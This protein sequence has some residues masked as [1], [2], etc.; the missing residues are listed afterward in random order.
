[1]IYINDIYLL[2][3]KFISDY[4]LTK[5]PELMYKP[6]RP[7]TCLLI[8][9]H[10]DYLICIPFRSSITHKNSYLFKHSKRSKKTRSG[11]DY[12]KVVLIQN[13]EYIDSKRAIIDQDEYKE[14]IQNLNWIVKEIVDYIDTHTNH[15]SKIKR[16]HNKKFERMYKYSTL[17]YF[18]DI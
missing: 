14:T 15:V 1:M 13:N 6:N 4:P 12:S 7:Y 9:T 18:H 16:I 17:P 8:D 5:Y 10:E 3:Q 2:S 11:L